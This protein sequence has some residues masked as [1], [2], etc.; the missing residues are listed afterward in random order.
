[1]RPVCP[2]GA[3]IS[4]FL[5]VALVPVVAGLAL[6][7]SLIVTQ[8]KIVLPSFASRQSGKRSTKHVYKDLVACLTLSASSFQGSKAS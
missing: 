7:L 1:M 3:L 5:S 2:D 8:V 4:P 6:V